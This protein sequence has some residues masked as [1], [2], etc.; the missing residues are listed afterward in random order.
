[1]INVSNGTEKD[2]LQHS[3]YHSGSLGSRSLEFK[4]LP[5]KFGHCSFEEY[6]NFATSQ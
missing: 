2:W 4:F 1:M 5:I 6:M 3:S